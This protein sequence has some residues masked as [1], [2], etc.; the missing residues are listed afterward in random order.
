M[1]CLLLIVV[2]V[3]LYFFHYRR[4]YPSKEPVGIKSY[5]VWM[6]RMLANIR[7][8][9]QSCY[10]GRVK[11]RSNN[12]RIFIM[13]QSIEQY[14]DKC[15]MPTTFWHILDW[16]VWYRRNIGRFVVLHCCVKQITETKTVIDFVV[17]AE[18]CAEHLITMFML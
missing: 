13:L 15:M 1:V 2:V 6:K 11:S 14:I 5:T 12:K 8:A 17:F 16:T 7:K 9:C 18:I 4:V 3:F 10:W